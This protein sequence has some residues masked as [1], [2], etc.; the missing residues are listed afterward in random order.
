MQSPAQRLLPKDVREIQEE[1]T[2]LTARYAQLVFIVGEV[3]D[4]LKQP[5]AK[6]YAMHGVGRRLGII[7]RCVIN[8]YAIFPLERDSFLDRN[9]LSDIAI[10]LHAFYVNIFG[11]LDNLAWVYVHENG[12]AATLKKWQ[13]NLFGDEIKIFFGS[14]FREY[15]SAERL[16]EW[17]DNF[18]KDFR[19]SLAHRI[20]L[21]VPREALTLVQQ[22]EVADIN[23]RIAEA[24]KLLDFELISKLQDDADNIGNPCPAFLHAVGES[25][26]IFLHAQVITDFKTVEEI[27]EKFCADFGVLR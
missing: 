21:Y 10:N 11:L 16:T 20:P 14:A 9:E 5:K 2:L 15:L 18:L 12:K 24:Y 27:V 6:E 13:I 7:K 25:K 3:T 23:K 1:L 17:Y 8:I 19:D 26:S 4:L 22:E